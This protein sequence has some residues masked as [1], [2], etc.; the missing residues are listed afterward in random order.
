MLA[1]VVELVVPVV[2]EEMAV[3]VVEQEVV[4][5]VVSVVEQV[6]PAEMEVLAV[7]VV[8]LAV[9]VDLAAALAVVLAVDLAAAL[10]VDSVVEW[11]VADMAVAAE[12]VVEAN[13]DI[14]RS[15]RTHTYIG[16]KSTHLKK[17]SSSATQ[18]WFNKNPT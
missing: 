2:L 8:E 5:L 18:L 16:H 9:L 1:L 6:V 4:E 3:S 10:V 12:A 13:T 11:V 15:H 14:S 17:L 7:S